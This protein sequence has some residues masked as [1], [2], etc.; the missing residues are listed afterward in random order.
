MDYWKKYWCCPYLVGTDMRRVSCEGGTC[1]RFPDRKT[2]K[3]W[4]EKYC[5][6]ENAD[7]YDGRWK[8]CPIAKIYEDFYERQ[9]HEKK[10]KH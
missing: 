8:Q 2:A 1:L 3:D 6:C 10:D 7:A 5:S 4:L 9:E